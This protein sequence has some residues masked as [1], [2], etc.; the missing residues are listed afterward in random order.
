MNPK[1]LEAYWI[2]PIRCS[3][4]P[5][6]YCF[7][8]AIFAATRIYPSRPPTIPNP[9]EFVAKFSAKFFSPY[10]HLS[11]CLTRRRRQATSQAD[12]KSSPFGF[13]VEARTA[14]TR[15]LPDQGRQTGR[16]AACDL[17]DSVNSKAVEAIPLKLKDVA[18]D[19]EASGVAEVNAKVLAKFFARG[20]NCFDV[21]YTEG[22]QR[23][24]TEVV[25][26][27]QM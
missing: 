11:A 22:G 5:L 3:D 25:M 1:G 20:I 8:W 23:H 19:G 26:D 14:E 6:V 13:K 12:S 4:M 24:A 9:I 10:R 18:T 21:T 15:R 7:L 27:V 16:A 2:I 17:I